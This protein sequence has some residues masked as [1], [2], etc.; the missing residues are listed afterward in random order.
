MVRI[1]FI[2]YLYYDRVLWICYCC[3]LIEKDGDS[4]YSMVHLHFQQVGGSSLT[5]AIC[6]WSF[7]VRPLLWG[8]PLGT[9]IS[10]VVQRCAVRLIGISKMV[11]V[12]VGHVMGW[13]SMQ[14]VPCLIIVEIFIV[15]FARLQIMQTVTFNLW[16]VV[17][18][19]KASW[20]E[21][22]PRSWRY[23]HKNY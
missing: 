19:L 1:V 2:V 12:C 10:P 4:V 22:K 14:D 8:C 9:L 23:V 7:H 6:A 15:G 18:P 16:F 3:S 17:F 13:H 11:W 5:F 21:Q 20:Q